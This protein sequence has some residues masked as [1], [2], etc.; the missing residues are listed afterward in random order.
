[1]VVFMVVIVHVLATVHVL[2]TCAF[3]WWLVVT[4]IH[5][6]CGD[7]CIEWL[8]SRYLTC[9]TTSMGIPG[10]S[11][12]MSVI[13]SNVQPLQ[14]GAEVLVLASQMGSNVLPW[15]VRKCDAAHQ[16]FLL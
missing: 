1:M 4:Y 12:A 13:A 9:G 11:Y 15:Q 7:D 10:T 6:L 2:E 14:P 5:K 16:I 3:V 8:C